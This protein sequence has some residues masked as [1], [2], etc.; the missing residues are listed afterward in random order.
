MFWTRNKDNNFSIQCTLLS[1]GLISCFF[2]TG[3]LKVCMFKES[4]YTPYTVGWTCSSMLFL[5]FVYPPWK[6]WETCC[7][8]PCIRSSVHLSIIKS[9]PLINLITVRDISKKLHFRNELNFWNVHGIMNTS[10]L[11]QSK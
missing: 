8:S 5:L 3:I 9:C 6:G 10:G 1:G 11:L 7:F 4:F 2:E